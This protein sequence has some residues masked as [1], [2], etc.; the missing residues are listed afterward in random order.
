MKRGE[1][2]FPNSAHGQ[3]FQV[4]LFVGLIM[5][6][7]GAVAAIIYAG[8]YSVS[9]GAIMATVFYTVMRGVGISV[10][11]H[12]LLTHRSFKINSEFL[13]KFFFY[14]GGVGGQNTLTWRA[15][16]LDHH[17][18]GDSSR[19]PYSPFWPYNGGLAGFY[20]AHV[21][22]LYHEYKPTE[23]SCAFSPDDANK[24][25]AIWEAKYHIPIFLSG[26]FIPALF[27]GWEG[28]LF[29]GFLSIVYVFHFTWAVNSVCH[30][31]GRKGD[32]KGRDNPFV[33]IFGF[34]GE[35]FHLKHHADPRAAFLGNK[36]WHLDV[37]KWVIGTL[38]FLGLAY[39]VR[40]RLNT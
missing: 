2:A 23:A 39:D 28:L 8:I 4:S 32:T 20:W 38:K 24:D 9:W 36:W 15:N 30:M 21:G 1:M 26:F 33:I 27:L 40:P 25:A 6:H 12:R 11:Y 31:W 34:V 37:G 14:W 10:G 3:R 29:P 13:R 17:R 19:D 22:A 35:G 7:L 16:H 18:Y 5:L